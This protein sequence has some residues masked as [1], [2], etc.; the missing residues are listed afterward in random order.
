MGKRKSRKS[1]KE[2]KQPEMKAY[3]IT[4]SSKDFMEGI[5]KKLSAISVREA[6]IDFVTSYEK[7]AE[8]TM[9]LIEFLAVLLDNRKFRLD[10]PKPK[11]QVQ[12]KQKSMRSIQ[13][14][15][16][17]DDAKIHHIELGQL[18]K[19]EKD[20]LFLEEEHIKILKK[21]EDF[22]SIVNIINE[23]EEMKTKENEKRREYFK[24]FK[25]NFL[26]KKYEGYEESIDDLSFLLPIED[27]FS[28]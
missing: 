14:D 5:L 1:T 3:H 25:T 22:E 13:L 17:I 19:R 10:P 23:H 18:V 2:P 21:G 20:I 27:D 7:A 28:F 26:T 16:K 15:E 12:K 11:E 8:Y 4:D 6:E 24:K 9:E